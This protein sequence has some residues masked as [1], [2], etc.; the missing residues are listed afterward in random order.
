VCFFPVGATSLDALQHSKGAPHWKKGMY[1]EVKVDAGATTT[2][3][4]G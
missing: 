1:Q 2:T 4:A 3:A